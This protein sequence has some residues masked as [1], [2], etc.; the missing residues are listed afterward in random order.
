[1]AGEYAELTRLVSALSIELNEI[2]ESVSLSNNDDEHDPDSARP[3]ATNGPRPPR[4]FAA[5]RSA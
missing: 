4:C 5:P 2:I 3:T 1:M